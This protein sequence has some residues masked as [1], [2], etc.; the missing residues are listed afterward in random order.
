MPKIKKRTARS[1][2]N[3][4]VVVDASSS[5]VAQADGKKRKLAGPQ[6]P[7]APRTM[8]TR[9]N[10]LLIA[11][12]IEMGINASSHTEG[13]R[14]ANGDAGS[15]TQMVTE[16][17]SRDQ[18]TFDGHPD[19]RQS[20]ST[21]SEFQTSGAGAG[22][23]M[24][25]ESRLRDQSTSDERPAPQ[26]SS[27]TSLRLQTSGVGAGS[28][29]VTES[30]SRDQS[31][32]DVRPVP[33]PSLVTIS[34]LRI[35]KAGAN[36]Q[37]VTEFRSRDQSTFVGQPV[38]QLSST[39]MPNTRPNLSMLRDELLPSS[40]SD[41]S[42]PRAPLEET[43]RPR[44]LVRSFE[45]PL[46]AHVVNAE[47]VP[48]LPG[49]NLPTIP[50]GG[51]LLEAGPVILPQFGSIATEGP[52]GVTPG[53]GGTS[54]PVPV[55]PQ[56]GYQPLPAGGGERPTT[57]R[58]ARSESED[59]VHSIRSHGSARSRQSEYRTETDRDYSTERDEPAPRLTANL[60][61]RPPRPGAQ[62][63]RLLKRTPKGAGC[64]KRR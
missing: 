62:G 28:Q 18:L 33:Q 9:K 54:A 20:S 35:S 2:L 12:L 26:L 50:A 30:R 55:V 15:G 22:S 3:N 56:P 11:S 45:M 17:R 34:E 51:L 16:S 42:R 60:R 41:T 31:T 49:P 19:S 64:C 25:T 13:S 6:K 53:G 40:G 1:T 10:P 44:T 32:S 7:A 39:T 61:R 8:S 58:A 46:S 4:D 48:R 29:M 36:P 43:V 14:L 52:S 38:S 21:A 57:R 63:D 59:D 27:V 5:A 47:V 37:M 23:Q 24:V